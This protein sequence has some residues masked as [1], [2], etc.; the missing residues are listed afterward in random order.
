MQVGHGE[1]CVLVQTRQNTFGSFQGTIFVISLNN[2]DS[3]FIYDQILFKIGL[4][5]QSVKRLLRTGLCV[6]D[7]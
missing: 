4:G 6:K 7:K 3:N 2:F 5:A 1:G